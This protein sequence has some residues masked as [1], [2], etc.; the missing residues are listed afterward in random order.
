MPTKLS[1]HRMD[2]REGATRRGLLQAILVYLAH[3]GPT[4]WVT[5]YLHFDLDGT[6]EI[7]PALGYLAVSKHIVFEGATITASG[8]EQ[9]QNWQE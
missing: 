6:G 9:L 8:T 5:L 1:A 4:I 2:E 3:H 7:G